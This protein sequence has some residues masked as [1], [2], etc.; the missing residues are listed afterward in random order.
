MLLKKQRYKWNGHV[1]RMENGKLPKLLNE[2]VTRGI[3]EDIPKR[4]G[5]ITRRKDWKSMA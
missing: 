3:K 1:K 5:E 2:L 4:G